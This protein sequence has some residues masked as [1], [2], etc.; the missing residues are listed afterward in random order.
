MKKLRIFFVLISLVAT[1]A[2]SADFREISLNFNEADTVK[3][4]KVISDFSGKGLV[5]PDS[6]LGVTTVYLKKVPWN[7]ALEA[8]AKTENLEIEITKSLI[9]VSKAK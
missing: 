4:L 5:L 9:V 7:E 8:I 6:E 1:Q 2:W 3:V